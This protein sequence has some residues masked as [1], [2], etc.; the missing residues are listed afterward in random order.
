MRTLLFTGTLMLIMLSTC[1]NGVPVYDSSQVQVRKWKQEYINV[2][3]SD[4]DFQYN[5][6]AQPV[7]SYWDQFWDWFWQTVS[8]FFDSPAGAFTFR[9]IIIPAAVLIIVY[10]IVRV[11]GMA[12]GS[13]F[14]K[15]N[16]GQPIAFTAFDEDIHSISFDEAIRNAAD[17]KNFRL[18]VRLLYLQTLKHLTDQGKINWQPGKT[19]YAYSLELKSQS[20]QQRF[21]ELTRRFEKNWYGNIV[22]T[23]EE[24]TGLRSEFADFNSQF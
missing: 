20:Y 5:K 21:M 22:A 7:K 6:S 10:F 9:W 11:T 17:T 14:G 1:A 19:N 8:R 3:K 2:Y 24:F 4:R 23:E 16:R 12:E 13:F 15:K 18:A